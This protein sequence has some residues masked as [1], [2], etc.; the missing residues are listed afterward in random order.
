MQNPRAGSHHGPQM[1]SGRMCRR[2]KVIAAL[3]RGNNA[4]NSFVDTWDFW[5]ELEHQVLELRA[6]YQI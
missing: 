5:P 3:E 2:V 6:T 1:G 4:A